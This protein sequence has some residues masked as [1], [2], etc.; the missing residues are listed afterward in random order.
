MLAAEVTVSFF[1]FVIHLLFNSHKD[2]INSYKNP[3]V[4]PCPFDSHALETI[5]F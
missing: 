2:L 3:V 1:I 4:E 5:S